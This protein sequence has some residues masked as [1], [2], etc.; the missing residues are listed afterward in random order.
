[1]SL[2]QALFVFLVD[3]T[4]KLMLGYYCKSE[5]ITPVKRY[6]SNTTTNWRIKQM[7]ENVIIMEKTEDGSLIQIDERAWT[8][9]MIA[10]LEH[11]NYLLVNEK[12]YEMVEGRL[13][14]NTGKM[15]L[16]VISIQKVEQDKKSF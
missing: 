7:S 6:I 10:M 2:R 8:V 14:V 15:E 5:T 4:G 11:A 12:E 16:L 13:N 1:M 9:E 3:K